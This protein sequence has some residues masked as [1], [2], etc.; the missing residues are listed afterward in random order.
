MKM[1]TDGENKFDLELKSMLEDASV[2]PSRR[3]WKGIDARL[4]GASA[5]AAAWWKWAGAG[6]ALAGACALAVS[7]IFR[8]TSSP[9]PAD[10]RVT[11]VAQAVAQPETLPEAPAATP[12]EVSQAVSAVTSS[13]NY[14]AHNV[15]SEP[16]ETVSES[17]ARTSHD[18]APATDACM[19]AVHENSST[20]AIVSD[21]PPVTEPDIRAEYSED[22]T[23]PAQSVQ[24]GFK[25]KVSVHLEGLAG[26]NV[27]EF[28]SSSRAR[29]FFSPG[30]KTS[31]GIVETS[32]SEYGIPLSLGVGAKVRFSPVL[33]AGIGVDWSLLTRT[34]A[35]KYQ[36]SDC[37]VLHTMQYIGIPLDIYYDLLSRDSFS[38]YAYAGGEAEYCISN[39]YTVRNTPQ[40]TV[41]SS[42]SG[43]QWSAHAGLGIEFALGR[44]VGLYL[45][46]GV[47]YYFNCG[48]P[49]NIR[50]DRPLMFNIKAGLRF[51]LQ[52]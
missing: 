20:G 29:G 44:T 16:R 15:A 7:L 3:V 36:G 14:L 10:D 24:A 21:T 25:P 46:P 11:L 42:V 17:V 31:D 37:D 6:L 30:S 22:W 8:G 51:N 34:F 26:S 49:S 39:R 18:A 5:P 13:R 38:V 2:T 40:T 47:S 1:L 50:T 19:T 43:L 27:G 4:G 28:G 23:E 12:A 35:G 33:S 48:Q 41:S 45:D 9:V 32:T 52:H